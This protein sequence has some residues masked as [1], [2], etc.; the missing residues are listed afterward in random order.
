MSEK[1]ERMRDAN[2]KEEGI[3]FR[4]LLNL[5]LLLRCILL[6]CENSVWVG[7]YRRRSQKG[8]RAVARAHC[9]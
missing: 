6:D 8:D 5:Q 9:L 2:L 3:N 7:C 1:N 4:H